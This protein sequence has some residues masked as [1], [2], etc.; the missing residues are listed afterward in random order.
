MEFKTLLMMLKLNLYS[1]KCKKFK[2]NVFNINKEIFSAL[3][4]PRAS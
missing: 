4:D 1:K 2:A 3:I